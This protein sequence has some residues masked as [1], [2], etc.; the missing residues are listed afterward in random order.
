MQFTNRFEVSLPP[1]Q[2]WPLLMDLQAVV[3]CMPG[4][5]IVERID[6]RRFK[7]KVSVRLGPVGLIFL[8]D[9]AFTDIDDVRHRATVEAQG[10]DAKGRG[11]AQATIQF[12]CQPSAAGSEV[13]I[14]TD[15]TLSGAVAQYGRGAGLIQNVANQIVAQFARNL[16]ARIGQLKAHEALH[17]SAVPSSMSESATPHRAQVLEAVGHDGTQPRASLPAYAEGYRD[18]FGA[19]FSAGHAAGLAAAAALQRSG[20]PIGVPGELPPMAP[21]KPIGGISLIF[22]SLWATVR[23]W[24]RGRPD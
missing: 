8:C 21:A 18:G 22:S 6:D 17:G 15:L 3:P 20:R 12:H 1:E 13:V 14:T 16:E 7:G 11:T 19:G 2:A 24:F 9:A 5:E 10:A 23:G 4:A